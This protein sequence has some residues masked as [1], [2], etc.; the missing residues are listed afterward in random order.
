[1]RL[2]DAHRLTLGEGPGYD[3]ASDTAWWFDISERRL[4]TH[5]LAEGRTIVHD[6]PVAASAMAVTPDGRQLVVAEGGLYL[7]DP[8]SGALALH[9]PLEAERPG[10]RSNDAR[11]HPCGAFW[12]ST[13]SWQAEPGAGAIYH[14]FRGELRALW[15]ALTIPNAICFAPDGAT[16]YF[17]DTPTHSVMSVPTDP[18]TGLPRGEPAVL[19]R[20]L[21]APP[22]G[23]VTDAAGNLWIAM[24]GAGELAGFDPA[25]RP[26]G[27]IAFASPNVTCPA[28]VGPRAETLLVTTARYGLTPEEIASRPDAGAT[29]VL[30]APAPG[31]FDPPV[32][33][34]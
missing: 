26:V 30:P 25:G 19:L 8:A 14:Y 1:M 17:A 12:I 20:D 6:L 4:F 24:W 21:A 9:Q 34:E 18:V 11:V 2:L 31:R 3:P 13:M 28:F 29:F 33:L 7:R 27:S 5:R 15:P 22:D 23:A 10:N 16:A 32:S